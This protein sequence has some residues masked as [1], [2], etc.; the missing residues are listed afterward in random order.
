M[1]SYK[2]LLKGLGISDETLKQ[3]Y[4][5]EKDLKNIIDEINETNKSIT[6]QVN[7]ITRYTYKDLY[8]EIQSTNINPEI[9]TQGLIS[10]H[11]EQ[12]IEN[13][14]SGLSYDIGDDIRSALE[15]ARLFNY[16]VPSDE[17]VSSRMKNADTDK[18]QYVYDMAKD[19]LDWY[20]EYR[21]KTDETDMSRILGNSSGI[22]RLNDFLQAIDML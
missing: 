16:I 3:F 8:E 1:P 22:F 11:T 7:N 9:F 5:T 12:I 15:K 18:I 2:S 6:K 4:R 13:D 20:Y 10:S 19:W 21:E 14:S 17:E